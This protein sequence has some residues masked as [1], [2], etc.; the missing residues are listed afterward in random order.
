MTGL[1]IALGAISSGD[2]GAAEGDSIYSKDFEGAVGQEWSTQKTDTSPSGETFLGRFVQGDSPV[3]LNFSKL[4]AHDGLT[5][6]FDLYIIG[7]MDG[8]A[9]PDLFSFA[10]EGDTLR[11]TT[12]ANVKEA[13][14][15]PEDYPGGENSAGEGSTAEGSLEYPDF[16]GDSTYRLRFEIPHTSH[17]LTFSVITDGIDTEVDDESW[18]L[19]N[20]SVVAGKEEECSTLLANDDELNFV[21]GTNGNDANLVGTPG[22]DYICALGGN[23]DIDGLGGN[24]VIFAGGGDDIA[25]GGA[26]HDIIHGEAGDDQLIGG[27]GND[28]LLEQGLRKDRNLLDGG[29]GEDELKAGTGLNT[30]RGG[31][32][33]DKLLGGD[34]VDRMFGEGGKDILRGGGGSDRLLGGP[35]LDKLSGGPEADR[36]FGNG[37]SDLIGGN[38]GGDSLYG[39]ANG[40][41]L[42]GGGGRD[43]FFGQAGPDTLLAEDGRVDRVINGGRGIDLASFDRRERAKLRSIERR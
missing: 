5:I 34:R 29:A 25:D 6:E 15:Y 2:A 39:G 33:K 41:E 13:Q 14:A 36:I 38:G 12:F 16:G 28:T 11:T 32:A 4:A 22:A 20:F 42:D 43:R 30:M 19:D 21:K 3:S 10:A 24:D 7:S 31:P 1:T 35:A 27:A 23:D 18:G 9:Q 40:D 26:G 17:D 8:N 37:G